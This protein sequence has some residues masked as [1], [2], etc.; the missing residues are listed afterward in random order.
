ML[1]YQYSACLNNIVILLQLPTFSLHL[2]AFEC[3]E[4]DV[5]TIPTEGPGV[6]CN[7]LRF[8]HANCEECVLCNRL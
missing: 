3:K 6:T 7:I 8:T 4:K 2:F 1:R 5:A